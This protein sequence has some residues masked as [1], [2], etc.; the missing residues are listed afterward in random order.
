MSALLAQALFQAGR[1]FS[2]D[3]CTIGITPLLGKFLRDAGF[4][5][6]EQKPHTLECSA[7]TP[8]YFALCENGLV[9][10]QLLKPIRTNLRKEKTKTTQSDMIL[11]V[12]NKRYRDQK[13]PTHDQYNTN[14]NRDERDSQ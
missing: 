6:I 11:P 12:L 3:G 2:P 9:G 4:E 7:G 10:A 8:L 1:S 13:E 14:R 5:H